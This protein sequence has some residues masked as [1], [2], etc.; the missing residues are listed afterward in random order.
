MAVLAVSS[1]AAA[2]RPLDSIGASFWI[3]SPYRDF[4]GARPV[5]A[6]RVLLYDEV[7]DPVLA[8]AVA[9]ELRRV[10][11][12]TFGRQGWRTPFAD[13]ETLRVYVTRREADGLRSLSARAV[14]GGRLIAPAIL[15]DGSGLS[16]RQITRE[17]SR[18]VHRA[19]LGGYGAPNS[20]FITEATVELLSG[21][22][23]PE[24]D[25]DASR[26]AA[27]GAEI[28]LRAHARALGRLYVEEFLRTA[29]GS[30]LRSVFERA[31]ETGED[32]LSALLRSFAEATGEPEERLMLRFGVR[33][34]ASLETEPGPARIGLLDL[35]NGA[36]DAS[37]PT[38][39]VLR[40]RTLVPTDQSAAL[41]V[42]WPEDG[43]AAAA[44][45]RYRDPALPA[46]VLYVRAGQPQTLPLSGVA[47]V[48]WI[49][50]G[51]RQ[52]GN[53]VRAP[54]LFEAISDFPFSGLSPQATASDHGVRLSWATGSHA[55]LAG[56][57]VFREELLPD[58]K[59]LRSGPQVLPSSLAADES[60][61]YAFLDTAAAPGI[62]YR[63][64]VWAVTSDGLLARAFSATL[65]TAD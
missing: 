33:L 1:R 2:Q 58:G 7:D 32:L 42:R 29:G 27:A 14:E 17:V 48:D 36:F 21:P 44:V 63:Y 64:T 41:R 52:R 15:V 20:S 54:A 13:G 65:R 56:W 5:L 11:A 57:A 35:Q 22:R 24:G 18:V 23:D 40:H 59:I 4:R 61:R 10:Q 26:I 12:D 43:G 51:E 9:A 34:Y 8:E 62:Y 28:D 45:V 50:A 53:T 46:D 3:E 30:G 37:A 16:E 19:I 60:F 39:L 38:G 6:G 55:E 25:A 31:G 49:V 47:R